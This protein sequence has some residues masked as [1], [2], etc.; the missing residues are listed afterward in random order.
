MKYIIYTILPIAGFFT[1]MLINSL[2]AEEPILE[3]ECPVCDCTIT[4]KNIIRDNPEIDLTKYNTGT[5]F[6]IPDIEGLEIK[7]GEDVYTA[8]EIKTLKK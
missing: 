8:I 2:Y 7:I 1:G 4:A 3:A 6:H 5:T